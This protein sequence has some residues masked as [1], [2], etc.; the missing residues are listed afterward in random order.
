MALFILI[1]DFISKNIKRACLR[2]Q[3]FEVIKTGFKYKMPSLFYR[4]F[5]CSFGLKHE[6]K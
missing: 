3:F 2:E 6:E 5:V 1:T 4:Q